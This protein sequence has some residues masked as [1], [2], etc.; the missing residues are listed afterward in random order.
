MV[1]DVTEESRPNTHENGRE[2][3]IA[4]VPIF[5]TYRES[6][7]TQAIEKFITLIVLNH[8]IGLLFLPAAAQGNRNRQAC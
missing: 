4:L 6:S 5:P 3:K 7:I 1:V 2:T 8:V